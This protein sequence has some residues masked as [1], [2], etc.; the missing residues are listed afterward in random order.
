MVLSVRRS[1]GIAGALVFLVAVAST[2]YVTLADAGGRVRPGSGT[3]V[4][5]VDF[6]LDGNA[7]SAAAQLAMRLLAGLPSL[8]GYAGMRI[9]RYGIEV[10]VVG[11]PSAAM[12]AVVARDEQQYQGKDIPVGYRSVRYSE[13]ELD[14]LKARLEADSAGLAAQ[15]IRL[16][17]WGI[18][19]DSNTVQVGLYHYTT[20][21]RD[22]LRARYGD[23][24]SVVPYD[25]PPAA[26]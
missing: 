3:P 7:N 26:A 25:V 15:G 6:S 5:K 11:K 2:V 4:N 21:Y 17:T 23:Q 22:L 16:T 12:R 24:I 8:P 14:A 1:W 9:V 18:D 19:L 13:R 10:D 20:A